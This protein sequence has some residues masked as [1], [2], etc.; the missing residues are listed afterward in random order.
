MGMYKCA[1]LAGGALLGSYGL[2]LLKTREAKKVYTE[3]TAAGAAIAREV[4]DITISAEELHELVV[5]KELSRLL[6]DRINWNYRTI[7]GFNSML[8]ILGVAGVLPAATTALL[9]NAST[10]AIGLKSMTPLLEG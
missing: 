10:L 6:M 9:H 1:W 4:A 7:M 3:V 2:K 5:L 8:I